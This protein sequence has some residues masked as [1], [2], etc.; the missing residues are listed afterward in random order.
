[1]MLTEEEVPEELIRNRPAPAILS[2][3]VC[4][5]ICWSMI[6]KT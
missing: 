5:I 4:S 6:W 2:A 3:D 1:M